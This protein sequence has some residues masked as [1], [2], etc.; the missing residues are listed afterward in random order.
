MMRPEGIYGAAKVFGEALGRYYS[1]AYG[2]SVLC[3]RI[4]RVTRDNKLGAIRDRSI[5]LSHDDVWRRYCTYAW[6]LPTA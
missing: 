1:D 4:G 3:V 6:T 5:Y 2:L